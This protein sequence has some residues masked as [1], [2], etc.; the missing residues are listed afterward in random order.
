MSSSAKLGGNSLAMEKMKE[1][2][3]KERLE[4]MNT[5]QKRGT[6]TVRFVFHVFKG[7]F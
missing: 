4:K 5:K 1:R 2:D 7:P 3:E 6:P